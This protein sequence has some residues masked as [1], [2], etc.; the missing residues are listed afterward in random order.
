MMTLQFITDS[1]ELRSDI[2]LGDYQAQHPCPINTKS[3]IGGES[4]KNWP[5]IRAEGRSNPTW[6]ENNVFKAGPKPLVGVSQWNLDGLYSVLLLNPFQCFEKQTWATYHISVQK[7]AK[8]HTVKCRTYEKEDETW[9]TKKENTLQSA[10]YSEPSLQVS[11]EPLD[12]QTET[13]IHLATT[14]F[15]F[16]FL[17]SKC[18]QRFLHFQH[19]QETWTFSI[20]IQQSADT[21][22]PEMFDSSRFT[23]TTS[24]LVAKQIQCV[25]DL[26]TVNSS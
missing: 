5:E 12:L 21:T 8:K 26:R 3:S 19:L 20:L 18:P 23:L 7:T 10:G 9:K 15:W 22:R 17:R 14:E 24:C 13:S 4:A 2:V 1:G 11:T 25:W 6:A 16:F